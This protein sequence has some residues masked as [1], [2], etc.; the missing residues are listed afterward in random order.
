MRDVPAAQGAKR[1][2]DGDV[3]HMPGDRPHLHLWRLLPPLRA[4][5]MQ[6]LCRRTPVQAGRAAWPTTG[7][8]GCDIILV[9]GY[10]SPKGRVLGSGVAGFTGTFLGAGQV[11]CTGF[12]LGAG[13]YL[14]ASISAYEGGVTARYRHV[15]AGPLPASGSGWAEHRPADSSSRIKGVLPFDVDDL[16]EERRA[17]N[18]AGGQHRAQRGGGGGRARDPHQ[19]IAIIYSIAI[20]IPMWAGPCPTRLWLVAGMAPTLSVAHQ[21]TSEHCGSSILEAAIWKQQFGSSKATVRQQHGRHSAAPREHQ[22]AVAC[23]TQ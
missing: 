17:A 12:F 16:H 22:G 9:S 7:G 3:Q 20:A 6:C 14:G 11:G 8:W 5:A 13:A 2:I 1:Q 23:L 4:E 15:W 10:F 18:A 19:G 21:P